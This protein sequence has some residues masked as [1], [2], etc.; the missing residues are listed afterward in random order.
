MGERDFVKKLVGGGYYAGS[1]QID[2]EVDVEVF[3]HLEKVGDQ[4]WLTL[5]RGKHRGMQVIPES[6]QYMAL[7]FPERGPIPDDLEGECIS[8]RK[9]QRDG[10]GDSDGGYQM[11]DY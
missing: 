7:P 4:T 10:I 11:E 3:Q 1:K 5:Q 8:V 9:L 2:Q 6:H